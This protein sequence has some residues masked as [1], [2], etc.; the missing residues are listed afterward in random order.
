MASAVCPISHNLSA[1]TSVLIL[2]L[3]KIIQDPERKSSCS[4]KTLCLSASVVR[5]ISCF[6]VSAAAVVDPIETL[7]ASFRY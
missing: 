5:I 7:T 4:S 6:I 1:N 3:T 2:V